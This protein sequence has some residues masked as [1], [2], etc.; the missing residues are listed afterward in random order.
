MNHINSMFK[1][2]SDDIVLGEISPN[3]GESFSNLISFIGL[4]N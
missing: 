4:D 2:D 3:W 1:S